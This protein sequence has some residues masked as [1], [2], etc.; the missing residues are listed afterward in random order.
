MMKYWILTFSMLL[1]HGYGAYTTHS[2]QSCFFQQQKH[3]HHHH[4]Q[5]KQISSHVKNIVNNMSLSL[6]S[7]R[8][9]LQ[10]LNG[11]HMNRRDLILFQGPGGNSRASGVINGNRDNARAVIFLASL[12]TTLS[13]THPSVAGAV[14][15]TNQVSSVVGMRNVK[16]SIAKLKQLEA[17][18]ALNEYG[19]LRDALRLSPI[20]DVRKSCSAVLRTIDSNN[21]NNDTSKAQQLYAIFIMNLEKMDA[22][23]LA[24]TRGSK[25]SDNE[26]FVTYQNTIKALEDF[27][28]TAQ[29]LIPSITSTNANVQS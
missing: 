18:V 20:S 13:I 10:I 23:A 15:T 25:L 29:E 2:T 22:T 14:T 26:F 3:H 28:S 16:L 27:M 7:S 1:S 9:T 11:E 5:H 24:A 21:N 19:A 6:P 4:Q 8:S 17:N 12:L